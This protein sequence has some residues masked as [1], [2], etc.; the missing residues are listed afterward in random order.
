MGAGAPSAV[1]AA[2]AAGF[3]SPAGSAAALTRA[4]GLRLTNDDDEAQF[5]AVAVREKRASRGEEEAR[6]SMAGWLAET[7]ATQAATRSYTAGG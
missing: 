6:A 2:A 1:A 5:A 7:Y 4:A 3:A